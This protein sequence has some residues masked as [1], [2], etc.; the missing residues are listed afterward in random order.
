MTRAAILVGALLLSACASRREGRSAAPAAPRHAEWSYEGEA[1]PDHWGDVDASYEQCKRG[2][3]Q[4]PIDLHAVAVRRSD[5]LRFDYRPDTLRIVNNGHTVQVDHQAASRLHVGGQVYAL[6]QYHVHSPSEHT[7][8]GEHF[9]LEIHFVHRGPGGVLA[10][11][12]VLIAEGRE[13]GSEGRV[14]RTIWSYL[15]ARAGEAEV[16]AVAVN[17]LDLIP[18]ERAYYFYLGSLTTPPC[19]ESVLWHVLA[20]PMPM[21]KEHIA[22]FRELYSDNARPVQRPDWCPLTGAPHPSHEPRRGER[23]R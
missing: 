3:L 23:S 4:S 14:V 11:V 16:A 12:G 17:P 18:A 8:N 10:V 2:R 9:P 22:A 15:P 6:T 20:E 7:F 1:S 19:T 13:V 21:S 5:D